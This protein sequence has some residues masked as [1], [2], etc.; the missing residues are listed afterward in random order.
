MAAVDLLDDRPKRSRVDAAWWAIHSI[1]A[2]SGRT[3]KLTSAERASIIEAC[4]TQT[5]D[6]L[7]LDHLGARLIG[8]GAYEIARDPQTVVVFPPSYAEVLTWPPL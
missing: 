4:K 5:G 2:S 3:R 7:V 8:R 1:N 6:A